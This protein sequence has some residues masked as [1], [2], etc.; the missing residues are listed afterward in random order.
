MFNIIS[1]IT[2]ILPARGLAKDICVEIARQFYRLIEDGHIGS[3][4][5]IFDR[6]V[7][8]H[9]TFEYLSICE[10][11]HIL[12]V[13]EITRRN[14][15]N[16]VIRKYE[17]MRR[18]YH[19]RGISKLPQT[20]IKLRLKLKNPEKQGNTLRFNIIM[21]ANSDTITGFD[22]NMGKFRIPFTAD[23]HKRIVFSFY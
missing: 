7:E 17:S 21:Y 6:P 12:R 18:R 9:E 8:Y 14:W 13:F 19:D 16:L 5:L 1:V 3:H 11:R 15:N 2:H 23:F 22:Y 4:E 20:P 10:Q